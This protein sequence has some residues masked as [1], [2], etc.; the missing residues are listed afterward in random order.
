M[1]IRVAWH[2]SGTFDAADGSGGSDG[3]TMRFEPEHSDGANSGLFIIHDL[4]LKVKASTM[5]E[6]APPWR[7][8]FTGRAF[9]HPALGF[10][11]TYVALYRG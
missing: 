6:L 2:A 9:E 11:S 8:C 10:F 3:A 5:T 4:L 1:A 7:S